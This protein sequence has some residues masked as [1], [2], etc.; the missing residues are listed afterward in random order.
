M[1]RKAIVLIC[2]TLFLFSEAQHLL[3]VKLNKCRPAG[4]CLDCGDVK[5]NPDKEEFSNMM[6]RLS[7]SPDLAYISGKIKFQIIVDTLGKACVM[8]HND[9]LKTHFTKL[10]IRELVQLRSWIPASQEGRPQ[11][12][13]IMME[14]EI[15][16]KK[17]DAKIVR[18]NGKVAMKMF[19]HPTNPEIENVSRK[20]KTINLKRYTLDVLN[21]KNSELG[22]NFL[23]DIAVD[24]DNI[25]WLTVEE[26]FL[27]FDGNGFVHVEQKLPDSPNYYCVGADNANVKWLHT[28][29]GL[30]SYNNQ[31]WQSYSQAV[32]TFDI[33]YRIVHNK[34]S[35]ETFF[36]TNL[37][38]V[39]HKEGRW[40]KI[41]QDSVKALPSNKV[42]FAR[43]D[44][45][46]NLW[47]GT[48][49]GTVVLR[50]NGQIQESVKAAD[51]LK[52]KCITSMDED[53]EGNL[54]F[55]L[56]DYSAK[57]KT[58]AYKEGGILIQHADGRMEEFVVENSG[59]P[60]NGINKVLFDRFEHI[61][62]LSTDRAGLIRFDLNDNWEVYNNLN[63]TVPTSIIRDMVMDNKGV[64]YVSTAQ[65]LVIINKRLH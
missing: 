47:I 14:F 26:S 12:A 7:R 57:E 24:N 56:I 60:V 34:A 42:L 25:L 29:S 16:D 61:L 37:G 6:E 1:L 38:L 36:C 22:S 21:S 55:S 8:S 10:I 50:P 28:K 3:P 43:R 48:N 41:N 23:G 31:Q 44:S 11:T 62:W 45:K 63:S 35:N 30:F 33:T 32:T 51:L 15:K 19:D 52:G 40:F 9:A 13:S 2:S 5:A 53:G 18:V 4:F 65:G 58:G 64:L 27:R 46:N 54:Y 20:Y 49:R 17:I 59:I 39:I